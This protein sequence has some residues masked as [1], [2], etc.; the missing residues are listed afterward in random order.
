LYSNLDAEA[1]ASPQGSSAEL[2]GS[3][4]LRMQQR[5]SE[6]SARLL[7]GRPSA[8]LEDGSSS[9]AAL[10]GSGAGAGGGG[11]GSASGFSTI[12][13]RDS[14]SSFVSSRFD[15]LGLNLDLPGLQVTAPIQHFILPANDPR[16]PVLLTKHVPNEP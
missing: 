12:A 7:G 2:A 8:L 11:G 1:A 10:F 9:F 15:D 13:R 6:D 3:D 4:A 5:Y 16:S 14:Q